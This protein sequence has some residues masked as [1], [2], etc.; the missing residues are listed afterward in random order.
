MKATYRQLRATFRGDAPDDK[1]PCRSTLQLLAGNVLRVQA[2][3]SDL[4]MH[5]TT[6]TQ[7]AP[8]QNGWQEAI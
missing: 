3:L 4:I 1:T 7:V 2:K 5:G 8:A 6:A